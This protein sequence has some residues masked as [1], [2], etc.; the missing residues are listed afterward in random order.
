MNTT[1]TLLNLW[2]AEKQNYQAQEI[3]SGVQKF[4]KK[5]FL[6]PEIFDL[7]E[8]KL[9]TKDEN[10]ENEFLEEARKHGRRAD[11]IVFINNEIIIPV[12]IERLGNIE[13]GV[14]QLFQYQTDWNKKYGILTDGN[15]WR[16]YVNNFVEK[17]F[18][19]N[20]ILET[21]KI[22]LQFW[23]EY[24]TEE[25][26]YASFFKKI[27]QFE[28]DNFIHIPH[29][30]NVR[31]EFFDDITILIENFA[32]KLLLKEY[33]TN[34]TTETDKKKKAIEITY[35]YFIQ[36]ILY[37]VLVDN[38]FTEFKTDFNQ[39]F[40]IIA[41][42]IHS[43]FYGEILQKIKGISN[44]IS[45]NI[46]KPFNSEQEII[47]KRLEEINLK[48]QTKITDIS[49]WLDILLFINRYDFSNVQNEIFGHVYENYLKDLY[50]DEKK[51]QYF[52][53]PEVVD[54]MLTEMGFNKNE[55]KQRYTKDVT[56][57]SIIDHSCGSG[58]FLYNATQRIIDTFFDNTQNTAKLVENLISENV[59]GLD[60]AEF[61]LYLAAMNMIMRM[62]PV[63]V[64]EKYNHPAEKKLKIFKTN[65]SIAE[66]LNTDITN[67]EQDKSVEISK[68]KGQTSLD[69]S[70]ELDL[71]Y[72]SFLR[73][74][75]NLHNLKQSLE[76]KP[77][78][79]RFDYVV[80]NPPYISYNDCARQNVL[81][82]DLIK[83][84]KINMADIYGVNLNS[85]PDKLKTY[86]PK[87]NLYSFFVA[88]GIALLKNNGTM[89]YII[90]QTLLTANDLDVLRYH[91]SHFVTIQKIIIFSGKMFLGRGLQQ[92]K[93]VATSSLIIIL[94]KSIPNEKHKIE[95]RNYE[96]NEI[97]KIDFNDSNTWLSIDTKYISQEKLKQNYDNWNFI[98]KNTKII[99]FVENYQQSTESFDI[100]RLFENSVP[101]FNDKFYFDVGFILDEKYFSHENNGECY[102]VLEFQNIKG[103]SNFKPTK[104][105]PKNHDLI[106]L[107]RSNQG[108]ITL[109]PKYNLVWRIKNHT[110]FKLI[111]RPIIFNMGA[112]SI[113]TSNNKNEMLYLL[114]VLNSN[115]NKLILETFLKIPTEKDYLLAILPIKKYIRV[116][117]I[118]EQN[119]NIKNRIIEKT[120]ELLNLEEVVLQDIVDFKNIFIQ[121]FEKV[122]VKNNILILQNENQI[123]ECKINKIFNTL[124]NLKLE[125]VTLYELKNHEIID[126]DLQKELKSE[127]DNLIFALYFNVETDKVKEHEFYKL[128]NY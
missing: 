18:F 44:I 6:S 7:K 63:I 35:A 83:R 11:I 50:L 127:I 118:N 26:Y 33:F 113:I 37:K 34:I 31:N 87:P 128:I 106:Q 125:N 108:H 12:E 74:E 64:N 73:D 102:E 2:N 119:I 96:N 123:I 15:E 78:R 93:A 45:K 28:K 101:R 3:G 90:P 51:G 80:G 57:V 124:Q 95:I 39:R 69:F 40:Q 29:L 126:I 97:F 43:G 32:N 52:T 85:T 70:Q 107:T 115:I 41:K 16:F 53:S 103:Y 62:L 49:V 58:T 98:T 48:P 55:L 9:S 88:L 76:N 100:Y 4:V 17:T 109:V 89:S 30:D 56:S 1:N 59:Y 112:A 94:K 38:N 105:Y 54:F 121:K 99:Q 47:N 5:V 13:K 27:G 120:Q 117:L 104:F 92:N 81:I 22:F 8:G 23:K 82:I 122:Y 21:P 114:S 24:T 10:R 68:K 86:P 36:F 19:I 20:E 72:K 91:L 79:T 14:T 46:Y 25:N 71:G 110:G 67:T 66:F 84:R 60:I 75:Q 42:A 77:I 61:P 65:D 111:D 116:P